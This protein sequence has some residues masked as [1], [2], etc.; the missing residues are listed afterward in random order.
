MASF[1]RKHLSYANLMATIAVFIA[2]GGS[3]YAI[4]L[5]QNS[6]G[7]KQIKPNAVN[8][9]KVADQSLSGQ[10]VQV[11]SLGGQEIQD[12]S[13]GPGDVADPQPVQIRDVSTSGSCFTD[14]GRF[15]GVPGSG[16]AQPLVPQGYAG[17]FVDA[18]G[19]VHLQG[20][21]RA[22]NTAGTE[23]TVFTL[24]SS[25]APYGLADGGQL[26]Y[27]APVAASSPTTIAVVKQSTH[28]EVNVFFAPSNQVVGLSGIT[29]RTN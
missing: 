29:W 9:T 6:V 3:A 17:Y 21:V 13:L 19:F 11:G 7:A 22:V 16:W 28:A 23:F 20:T 2:L 4:K 15:C 18:E 1:A 14:P 24:P 5:K 10:D 26:L 27:S 25:L 8:G 12:G